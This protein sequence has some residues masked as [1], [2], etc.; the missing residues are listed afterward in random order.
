MLQISIPF[1][2]S[3]LVLSLL[4][5]AVWAVLFLVGKH[6][7]KEQILMSVWFTPIGPLSEIFFLSD[8]WNPP[9]VFSFGLG[10][11]PI[12]VEDLIFAFA[13]AGIASVIYKVIFRKRLQLANVNASYTFGATSVLIIPAA[14]LAGFWFNGALNSIFMAALSMALT[15]ILIVVQRK[16]LLPAALATAGLFALIVVDIN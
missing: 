6:T 11:V 4:F 12:L 16:D 5:L 10:P 1:E 13:T 2:Y 8:Y 7:R 14:L 3:Y 9:S 15:A